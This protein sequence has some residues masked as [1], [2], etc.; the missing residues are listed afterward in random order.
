MALAVTA[1]LCAGVGGGYPDTGTTHPAVSALLG[2]L[3]AVR[4]V[5]VSYHE[6]VVTTAARAFRP[7]LASV[8]FQ[9]KADRATSTGWTLTVTRSA[10]NA[11][12]ILV[13]I[14]GGAARQWSLEEH[15]GAWKSTDM[16]AIA[17]VDPV[18]LG[19]GFLHREVLPPV[20]LGASALSSVRVDG[21]GTDL[22]T[23][24]LADADSRAVVFA[25]ETGL[26]DFEGSS[27]RYSV[28]EHVDEFRR[29]PVLGLVPVRRTLNT[30][31]RGLSESD[32]H[33]ELKRLRVNGRSFVLDDDDRTS[34]GILR[35]Q[36]S[37]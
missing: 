32:S 35:R 36:I 13:E 21:S 31:T 5:E 16:M 11:T 17:D 37:R 27:P 28:R 6:D 18:S 15:D 30:K 10:G 2:R 25:R 12:A 19:L 20:A 8:E 4:T 33:L 1:T 24:I 22:E 7:A 23:V 29:D 3:D 9:A 26:I 34:E 14:S